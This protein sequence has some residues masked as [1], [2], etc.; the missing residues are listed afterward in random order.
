M[1]QKM[2]CWEYKN[3]GR[4]PHGNNVQVL[5]VCPAATETKLHGVHGGVNAGRA[6]W[7]VA[8]TY[9]HG[10]VQGTFSEKYATCR[11][12]DFYQKVLEENRQDFQLSLELMRKLKEV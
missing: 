3:C 1:S 11:E 6:C 8:G 4:E 5:G 12:C 2:N 10:T 9:C 7:V